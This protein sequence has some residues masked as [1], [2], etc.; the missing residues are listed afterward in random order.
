MYPDRAEGIY[1]I[2]PAILILKVHRA[3]LPE[4]LLS[5]SQERGVA[6]SPMTSLT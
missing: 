4:A 3:D 2:D 5:R 6:G 1:Q